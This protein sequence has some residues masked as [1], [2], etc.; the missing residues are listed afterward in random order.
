MAIVQGPISKTGDDKVVVVLVVTRS[1][2]LQ[3]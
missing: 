1:P 3:G 2:V